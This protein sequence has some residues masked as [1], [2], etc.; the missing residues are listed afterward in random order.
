MS[1]TIDRATGMLSS[2][3]SESEEL[4]YSSL[5]PACCV[6][7]PA[8]RMQLHRA[9]TDN[10]RTGYSDIW[11]ACGLDCEMVMFPLRRALS[12]PES[13]RLP[14][15]TEVAEKPYSQ[16]SLA[17]ESNSGDS[18]YVR[19]SI[20]PTGAGATTYSSQDSASVQ[21]EW[22]MVP[23]HPIDPMRIYYLQQMQAFVHD[24]EREEMYVLVDSA[25]EEGWVQQ[26]GMEFRLGRSSCRVSLPASTISAAVADGSAADNE[27]A[28]SSAS[29]R[30][31]RAVRVW[32]AWLYIN[33][34]IPCAEALI[35]GGF[36]GGEVGVCQDAVTVAPELLISSYAANDGVPAQV[37]VQVRVHYCAT[38]TLT[39]AGCLH[40]SVAVDASTVPTP[41]PRVGLQLNFPLS[42]SQLRWRGCGPH[43]NYPDR[44]AS[45]VHAV[46]SADL[47]CDTLHVPYVRPG[48]NGSRSDVDWL[49]LATAATSIETVPDG[50]QQE[51]KQPLRA[52]RIQADRPFHFSAQ[53]HTTEDLTLSTHINDLT[54]HPRGFL[55]VNLDPHLMGV[56]GDDSWSSCVHD[57]W[58]LRAHLDKE[59]GGQRSAGSGGSGGDQC[60][61]AAGRGGKY[62]YAL[63]FHVL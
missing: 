50:E 17:Q 2:L 46:H 11:V 18:E 60:D 34:T 61:P 20:S 30:V 42:L 12:S 31:V 33:C 39:A 45:A 52:L 3:R 22:T 8:C 26:L 36:G 25:Q 38:Y 47:R 51:Q 24:A 19:C 10:D 15:V 55:A 43:E 44:R 59:Q 13:E 28:K 23:R 16:H 56:G 7:V 27:G 6:T 4:L 54:A 63:T 21:C 41:L 35:G 29:G 9:P 37:Q 40:M 48:E 53:R 58:E 57:A 62:V 5:P 32:K 49:Q 1:A 14:R